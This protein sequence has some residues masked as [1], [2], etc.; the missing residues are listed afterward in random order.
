MKSQDS[1][2]EKIKTTVWEGEGRS[3]RK[4]KRK[5][6]A[7]RNDHLN[8]LISFVFFLGHLSSSIHHHSSGSTL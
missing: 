5:K 6:N 7:C 4:E 3:G 2:D 1:R 8:L